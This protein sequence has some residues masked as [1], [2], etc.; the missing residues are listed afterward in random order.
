[1]TTTFHRHC[2][3][4]YPGLDLCRIFA[5]VRVLLL[6]LILGGIVAA[7]TAFGFFGYRVN[8]GIH[9]AKICELSLAEDIVILERPIIDELHIVGAHQF[10]ELIF[11]YHR[12][13]AYQVEDQFSGREKCNGALDVGGRYLR[14]WDW[15]TSL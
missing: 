1:M 4:D 12:Q 9:P 13:N 6:V 15:L 3:G 7:E 8:S 11:T 14:S 2:E 5:R 10:I